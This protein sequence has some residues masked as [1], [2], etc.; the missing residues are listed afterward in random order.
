MTDE[1]S[2]WSEN[3]C[4]WLQNVT[5]VVVPDCKC[6]AKDLPCID[7]GMFLHLVRC[8]HHAGEEQHV[9]FQPPCG[10]PETEA[11]EKSG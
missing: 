9:S 8:G 5:N 4:V 1:T 2:R 10:G 6:F 3:V 7:F 11:D